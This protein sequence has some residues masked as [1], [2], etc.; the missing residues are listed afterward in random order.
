MKRMLSVLAV[1]AFTLLACET[2][3]DVVPEFA[4]EPYEAGEVT[5]EYHGE[6]EDEIRLAGEMNGWT[7]TGDDW[8]MDEV[9]EDVWSITVWLDPGSYQYKYIIDGEWT[10]PGAILEQVRPF[11]ND[12]S[13]DGF[14]GQNAVIELQ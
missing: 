11:P 2:T 8:V 12:E 5:F 4:D 1:V 3:P 10:E 6:V 9:E 7:E 13:D 14:G